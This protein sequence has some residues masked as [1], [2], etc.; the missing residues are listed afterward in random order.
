MQAR[1]IAREGPLESSSSSATEETGTGPGPS[2]PSSMS[3]PLESSSSSSVHLIAPEDLSS[4]HPPILVGYAFSAKKMQTM[5][6]IMAEASQALSSIFLCPASTPSSV[7]FAPPSLLTR[8]ALRLANTAISSISSSSSSSPLLRPTAAVSVSTSF[9][10]SPRV[11]VSSARVSFVPLDLS[12]SL[13]EQH[14]GRFDV[15]LHKLTEDVRDRQNGLPAAAARLARLENY[16]QARPE[17][18]LVDPPARLLA[19][20][21]RGATA[22]RLRRC[23]DGVPGV[24][25]PR[26]A[27]CGSP[28]DFCRATEGKGAFRRP[29]VAKPRNAAGAGASHRM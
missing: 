6:L 3:G 17:C 4:F 29:V 22:D 19:V 14:G 21:D 26:F 20:L 2:L 16:A 1:Q 7:A 10:P 9:V 18:R 5:S 24:R 23:L 8:D 27:V 11:S 28:A 25:A 13:E 12:F 15:L